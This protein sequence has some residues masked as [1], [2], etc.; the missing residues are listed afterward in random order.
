MSDWVRGYIETGVSAVKG[1]F[2]IEEDGR[3]IFHVTNV[4]IALDIRLP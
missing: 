3:S 4:W 2:A 1:G